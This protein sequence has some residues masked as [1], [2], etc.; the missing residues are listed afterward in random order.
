MN[1]YVYK[2]LY[3]YVNVNNV[4][5]VIIISNNKIAAFNRVNIDK[6]TRN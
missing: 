1:T 4:A 6:T 2:Q 5:V 3:V